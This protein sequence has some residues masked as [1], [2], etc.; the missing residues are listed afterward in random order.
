M[1]G[2]VPWAL[3]VSKLISHKDVR[4]IGDGNP[5]VA[6]AWKSGGWIPGMLSVGLEL[7][8]SIVPIYFAI[9]FLGQPTGLISHI[10]LALILLA[11]IVGHGW[12]PFLKFKG[13]KSLAASWGSWI[14]VTNG[15]ALPVGCFFLALTH[16]F[17]KNHSVT[18]T[19]CLIGFIAVFALMGMELFLLLF[20]LGNISIV[21]YKH[22]GEYSEGLVLRNWIHKFTRVVS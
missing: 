6:N 17:Q 11:P 21:I 1:S 8:K 18:V 3:V 14:A 20:S 15:M 12:S 13:G 5:G 22:R 10:G 4:N 9:M 7:G 16:G 2:S 19:L